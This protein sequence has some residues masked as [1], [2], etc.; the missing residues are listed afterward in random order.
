MSTCFDNVLLVNLQLDA[1]VGARRQTPTKPGGQAVAFSR[2]PPV[3][4]MRAEKVIK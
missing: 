4:L 2:I 1:H 3:V